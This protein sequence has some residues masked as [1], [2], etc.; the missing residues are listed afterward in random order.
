MADIPAFRRRQAAERARGRYLGIGM[1]TFIEA[2]PG[3]RV[4]GASV[5]GGVH[6]AAAGR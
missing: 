6:A 5:M 2:A 3:P 1:A 4:P